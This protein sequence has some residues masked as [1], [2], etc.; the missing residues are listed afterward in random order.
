[1]MY[2]CILFVSG[3]K[4]DLHAGF[5][6]SR[7]PDRGEYELRTKRADVIGYS[8]RFNPLQGVCEKTEE[9]R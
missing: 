3:I 7:D 1:M 6:G 5:D 2:P 4:R 9:D 8:F